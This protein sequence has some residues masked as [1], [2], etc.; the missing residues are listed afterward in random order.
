MIETAVGHGEEIGRARLLGAAKELDGVPVDLVVRVN[1]DASTTDPGRVTLSLGPSPAR[2]VVVA[3][4]AK[5]ARSLSALLAKAAHAA[6]QI[7]TFVRSNNEIGSVRVLVFIDGIGMIP[8]DLPVFVSRMDLHVP[9]TVAV[10]LR[11]E[12]SSFAATLQASW[13]ATEL[14]N[15]LAA[16]ATH[17]EA[18]DRES[19]LRI[20]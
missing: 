10:A 11:R 20:H 18:A 1:G 19:A 12:S 2:T 8:Y 7:P 13:I 5:E 14:A 6:E 17:A 15:M 3:L 16:A 4:G 9:G